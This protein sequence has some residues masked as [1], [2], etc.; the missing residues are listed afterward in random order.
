M[1]P[2]NQR[3]KDCVS[4]ASDTVYNKRQASGG[5]LC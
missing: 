2:I 3:L 1:K 4:I 5:I